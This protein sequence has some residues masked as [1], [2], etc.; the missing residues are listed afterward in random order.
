VRELGVRTPSI[1]QSIYMLSGGNQQKCILAR[2]LAADPDI[3][4]LDEPTRGI[5]VG[6]RSEIYR[7]INSLCDEGKGVLMVTSDLPEAIGM[8]DRILV[9]RQGRIVADVESAGASQSRIMEHAFGVQSR[10]LEAELG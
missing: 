6:A 1:H 2:V 3:I 5:D 4:I 10:D 9:M 7:L 8:S